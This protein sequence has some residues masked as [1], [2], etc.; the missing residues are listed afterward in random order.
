[1]CHLPSFAYSFSVIA[2]S[3][4]RVGWGFLFATKK[5]NILDMNSKLLTI[6]I[7]L[8]I[9][10]CSPAK[11]YR[12]SYDVRSYDVLYGS[13]DVI[14]T[15]ATMIYY[16]DT[17]PVLTKNG[18]D[19]NHGRKPASID[20]FEPIP[21][22]VTNEDCPSYQR[23]VYG[24]CEYVD[25]IEGSFYD[26]GIYDTAL[27]I[28]TLPTGGH[29]YLIPLEHFEDYIDE[30]GDIE[31]QSGFIP[32]FENFASEHG[33]IERTPAIIEMELRT[34]KLVMQWHEWIALRTVKPIEGQI[35]KILVVF[36][37]EDD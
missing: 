31:N 17:H 20:T 18:K 19:T 33:V 29:G 35:K 8:A 9:S 10:A 21:E 28:C 36:E 14:S 4:L 32:N 26:E 25:D 37:I 30:Y 13:A 15:D 34:Y 1:M 7:F 11:Q 23:C 24:M 12:V 2:P 5:C 6:L 27:K 16:P 3:S 22:C